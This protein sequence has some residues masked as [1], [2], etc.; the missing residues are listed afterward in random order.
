MPM[1]PV[2]AGTPMRA[3][4]PSAPWPFCDEP[5]LLDRLDCCDALCVVPPL[6]VAPLL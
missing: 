6:W 2:T 5:P 4:V 3:T 1:A